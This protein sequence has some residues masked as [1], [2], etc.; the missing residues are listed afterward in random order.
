MTSVNL[1]K[2][3]EAARDADA[4]RAL[5]P[6]ERLEVRVELA[7]ERRLDTAPGIGGLAV[8]L[9]G[10]AAIAA[11]LPGPFVLTVESAANV[12]ILV[13][14]MAGFAALAFAIGSLD[15]ERRRRAW[16]ELFDVVDAQLAAEAAAGPNGRSRCVR[17]RGSSPGSN[18]R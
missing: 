17:G 16:R 12:I 5:T 11:I 15:L 1:K 4:Y 13:S 3:P 8:F 6:A 18:R 14:A 2:R 9:T 10:V 7:L